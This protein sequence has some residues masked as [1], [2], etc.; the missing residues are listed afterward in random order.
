MGVNNTPPAGQEGE[1]QIWKMQLT[2]VWRIDVYAVLLL[3]YIV[4]AHLY[5]G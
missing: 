3:K 1:P 4:D 5:T 2:K